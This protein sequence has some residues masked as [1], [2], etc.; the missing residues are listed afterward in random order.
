MELP[1]LY[2]GKGVILQRYRDGYL[3]DIKSISKFEGL[4]WKLSGGRQR[5]EKDI[6]PWIGKR[7]GVGK[8][9]PN[10]FPRPPKFE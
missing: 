7:G 10:G 2:K 5:T 4:Y 3:E 1:E 9:V 6:M 8:L